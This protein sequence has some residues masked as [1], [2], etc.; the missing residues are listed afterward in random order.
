M[1]WLNRP[2][3]NPK[4]VR[5]KREE[6]LLRTWA[7]RHNQHDLNRPE[8]FEGGGAAVAFQNDDDHEKQDAEEDDAEDFAEIGGGGFLLGE[9]RLAGHGERNGERRIGETRGNVNIEVES[10]T[11]LFRLSM[12]HVDTRTDLQPHC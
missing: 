11:R 1:S 3:Q 6:G 10:R 12:R 9:D 7:I 5:S 2:A 8:E 4:H